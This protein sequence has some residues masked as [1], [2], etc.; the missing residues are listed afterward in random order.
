MSIETRSYYRDPSP[1]FGGG[2]SGH[3]VVTWLMILNAV[4][5]LWDGIFWG[6][7]RA[8]VLAF[9]PVGYFSVEKAVYGGQ[10]WRFLTYQFIHAG[11]AHIFFNMLG[12][13]F[14][15]PMIERWWGG[16]RFLAFYLLCGVSGAVV[17]SVLALTV[18]PSVMPLGAPLVGASG[19]LFGILVACAVLFP[20]QRVML[21]IPP[22][23]MTMRTMAMVFLGIALL[24]VMAG[25][26]NAGGEA[27]HLGGA[28]LGF[29]LVRNPGWLGW[30]DG[31][32]VPNVKGAVQEKRYQRTAHKQQADAQEVDRILAKVKRQG[33]QSLTAREKK[34]LNRAT[35]SQ[36]G[37]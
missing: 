22:I 18:G 36:R 23:P 5:F 4:A 8:S 33:L 14:F 21:L 6:S 20:T 15:G 1:R 34:A 10:V 27:A 11:F 2:L 12:L 9:A 30:A 24:S 31:L 3:S 16:R 17:A 19:S 37:G 29:V 32:S 13:Y 35:E 7:H 26:Q 25:S 28:V